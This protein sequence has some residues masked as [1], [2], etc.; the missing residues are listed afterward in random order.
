MQAGVNKAS[1]SNAGNAGNA[2]PIYLHQVSP[3]VQAGL[4]HLSEIYKLNSAAGVWV[5]SEAEQGS[6]AVPACGKWH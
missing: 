6:Y 4:L 3:Q 2:S 5:M 1:F